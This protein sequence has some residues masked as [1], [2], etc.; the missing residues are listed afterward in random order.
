MRARRAVRPLH[1]AGRMSND[2]LLEARR[3]LAEHRVARARQLGVIVWVCA[4]A[5]VVLP[6]FMWR[7]GGAADPDA[8]KKAALFALLPAVGVVLALVTRH[9]RLRDIDRAAS[10]LDRPDEIVWVYPAATRVRVNGLGAGTHDS[11]MIATA[12][13]RMELLWSVAARTTPLCAALQ[14]ALP[15]AT[16]GWTKERMAQYRADPAS[17]RAGA[18]TSAA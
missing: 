12:A 14:R 8:A 3:V 10:L 18:S 6:L 7:S 5:L 4:I 13:G 2:G 16:I 17:L 15:H 9:R 1:S 11:V